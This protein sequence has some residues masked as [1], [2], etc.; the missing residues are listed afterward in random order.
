MNINRDDLKLNLRFLI[1]LI[2]LLN[3]LILDFCVNKVNLLSIL[4]I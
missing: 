3:F 2:Y 1:N 4:D